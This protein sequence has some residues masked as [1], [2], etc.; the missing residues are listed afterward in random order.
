MVNPAPTNIWIGL[1]IIHKIIQ[2][3][4]KLNKKYWLLRKKLTGATKTGFS[5]QAS[6]AKG[7]EAVRESRFYLK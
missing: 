7:S 3:M 1:E 6:T 5:V 2:D 4:G